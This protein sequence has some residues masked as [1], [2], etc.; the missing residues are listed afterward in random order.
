MDEILL[1]K[2]KWLKDILED[3]PRFIKIQST[4]LLNIKTVAQKA[5]I[6]NVLFL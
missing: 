5:F 3:I 4:F 2:R 1:I 6:T